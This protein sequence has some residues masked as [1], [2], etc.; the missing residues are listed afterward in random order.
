MTY[1]LFQDMIGCTTEIDFFLWPRRDLDRIECKL[2]SRWKGEDDAPYKPL[3]VRQ[4]YQYRESFEIII[5]FNL[6][7]SAKLTGNSKT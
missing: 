5:Q 2:F 4:V 1:V 6:R 7:Y 3:K